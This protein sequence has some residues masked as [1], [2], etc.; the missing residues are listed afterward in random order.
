MNMLLLLLMLSIRISFLFLF[1]LIIS[2]FF[3]LMIRRPPRSTRTD[4]LFPYTALFRSVGNNLNLLSRDTDN[5][6]NGIQTTADPNGGD[7]FFI[8]LTNRVQEIGRAHV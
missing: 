8:E 5:N 2:I 6:N 1:I 7:D 3:F 4:T